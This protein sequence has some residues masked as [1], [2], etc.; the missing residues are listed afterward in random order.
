VQIVKPF[1]IKAF[2]NLIF[3]F[4]MD[5]FEYNFAL[6]KKARESKKITAQ[7]IAN[8]LCL[9]ERQ[10]ISMEEN[11][12]QYFPSES[13]KYVCLKKY[14]VALGLNIEDVIHNLDDVDPIPSLLKKT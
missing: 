9:A 13:L 3:I 5:N 14:I 10:I 8:D 1:L 7:S 12:L 2:F 6:L 4:S 11:S